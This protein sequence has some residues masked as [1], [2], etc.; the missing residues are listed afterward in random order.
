MDH[1][2]VATERKPYV[3]CEVVR[4]LVGPVSHCNSCHEDADSGYSDLCTI[5][6]P[7]GFVAVCCR[8]MVEYKNALDKKRAEE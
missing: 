8:V 1:P 2:Y 3:S 6:T 5:D 4:R 7:K